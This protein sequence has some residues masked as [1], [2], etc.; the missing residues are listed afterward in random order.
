MAGLPQSTLL[1]SHNPFGLRPKGRDSISVRGEHFCCQEVYNRFSK[2][3]AEQYVGGTDGSNKNDK[4]DEEESKN[5][6]SPA[7][8]TNSAE[9]N[10]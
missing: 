7:G 5:D 10:G 9:D 8:S 6:G 3:T 2:K 1:R 4:F